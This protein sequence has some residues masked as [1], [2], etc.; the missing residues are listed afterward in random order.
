MADPASSAP[1]VVRFGAFG[2]M[3]LLIPMLKRLQQRYGRPCDLVSSGGWTP[4]LMQRVP[5]CGAVRLL[6]S[7][8]APYWFNRSQRELVRWLRTRPPGPV[9]V[10]EPDEKSHWLLR[11]GGIKPGWICSLRDLPRLPGENILHHALRLGGQTPAAWAGPHRSRPEAA[12]AA[13]PDARPTL[14]DADRRDC[15]DWLAARGLAG[16]ALVLVQ[17]GNKK[18]MRRGARQRASNVKYWPEASW[19]RVARGVCEALPHGRVLICGSPA[20]RGLAEAIRAAAG[21]DGV[22]VATDDLPIPR[23]LALQEIAHSMISVDTGPAHAA[24][25]M[26]CPLVV[27]FAR[28]DPQLYA[29]TPT[30]AAV[31]LVTPEPPDGP[32]TGIAPATVVAAWRGLPPRSPA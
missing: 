12:P 2:D 18:T 13:V 25:A 22:V 8:R 32:M 5:A 27:M 19:G 7:R 14:A 4:P 3:V 16:H 29:P 10:F 30:T 17:P 21:G 31:R 1:L 28:I 11:R 6:T 15:R 23:L 20:E 24:A 26:G 9:Y